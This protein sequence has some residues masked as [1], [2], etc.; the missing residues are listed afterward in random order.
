MSGVTTM[1]GVAPQATG[2]PV[3]AALSGVRVRPGVDAVALR[4][5]PNT[6][7]VFATHFPR[8]PILPGVLLVATAVDVAVLAAPQAAYGWRLK[9][10]TRVRWRR[11]VRPGDQ[12]SIHAELIGRDGDDTIHFKITAEVAGTP[13]ATI[14]LLTVVRR[15]SAPATATDSLKEQR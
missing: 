14:R 13:V 6:L 9:E 10:A 15:P 8:F 4:N 5:I 11:P 3:H 7:E 2:H 12:V 1:S